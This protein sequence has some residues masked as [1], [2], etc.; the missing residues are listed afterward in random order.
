MGVPPDAAVF[1]A[2]PLPEACLSDFYEQAH[3]VHRFTAF[4]ED[5]VQ[6]VFQLAA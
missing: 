2:A 5:P 3:L 1:G 4:K 6:P